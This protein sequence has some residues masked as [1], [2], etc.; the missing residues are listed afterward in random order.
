MPNTPSRL[1][2]AALMSSA[3]S[4]ISIHAATARK[5]APKPQRSHCGSIARVSQVPSALA[6]AWLASVA[7]RMPTMI[8]TGLR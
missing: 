4:G 6:P 1:V 5:D 2:P 7:T 3:L 8:G